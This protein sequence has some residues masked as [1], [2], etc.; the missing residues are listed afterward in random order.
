MTL[1]GTLYRAVLYDAQAEEIWVQSK[2]SARADGGRAAVTV[3]LP[4]QLLPRG[5]Y[6]LKL[7]GIDQGRQTEPVAAYGLRV[8]GP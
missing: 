5:D 8:T 3:V 6:Q 7:S 2:L 1:R 4:S